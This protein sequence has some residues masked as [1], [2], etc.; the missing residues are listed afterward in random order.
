VRALLGA[1]FGWSVIALVIVLFVYLLIAD[2]SRQWHIGHSG[3]DYDPT[4]WG[5]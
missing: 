2:M 5:T 4:V 3:R 1:L